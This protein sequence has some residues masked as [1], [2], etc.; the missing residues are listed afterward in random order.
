MKELEHKFNYQGAGVS[1]APDM[2][3]GARRVSEKTISK[4][5]SRKLLGRLKGIFDASQ[6]TFVG[7][8]FD[9][10]VGKSHH[11]MPHLPPFPLDYGARLEEVAAFNVALPK[12]TE[13]LVSTKGKGLS[14]GNY[15]REIGGN[16]HNNLTTIAVDLASK[17]ASESGTVTRVVFGATD[18]MPVRA[19]S[20]MLP[21]LTLMD[22]MEQDGIKPPQ[23]QVIFANHIS[24]TLNRMNHA[25]VAG[26][27]R[28]FTGVAQEYIREFFPKLSGSTVFL[29]DTP[30]EK[31]SLLRERL[32]HVTRS[33][34][35]K[36]PFETREALLNKGKNGARRIN[37]FYGAAHILVHD[38]DIPMFVPIVS[39]QTS[40][41]RPH[42]I[43][44]IGGY[45]EQ[46]F[47]N[48]RHEL[49]PHLGRDYNEVK[50]LQYFTR[51]RVPPYYMARDGDIALDEIL[52]RH[53]NRD[54]T[55]GKA[56]QYDLNYLTQVSSKRGDLETFFDRQRR[57]I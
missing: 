55:I 52:S 2:S 24:S 22:G 46:F 35:D 15:V 39:E 49:K 4:E 27:S 31:N 41:V 51:H 12:V 26:E 38:I 11:F 47:Y 30:L 53:R 7:G 8:T 44:S 43:I 37:A 42:N 50:T 56:A 3:L 54:S 29:E 1:F 5:Y 14:E 6:L 45:Q 18:R 20:Y 32:L 57:G 23:L 19:L 21:T 9:G 48:L 10:K 16:D 40:M 25:H 33:L 17:G 13:A 36:V 34:K 28:K